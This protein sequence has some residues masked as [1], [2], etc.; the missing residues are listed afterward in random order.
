MSTKHRKTEELLGLI[1][2]VM[3]ESGLI[4][5]ADMTALGRFSRMCS[6]RLDEF[7]S[8]ASEGTEEMIP[9][10]AVQA[11]ISQALESLQA[12]HGAAG[13][14]M[15]AARQ[16]ARV[17]TVYLDSKKTSV[18][19]PAGL[20]ESVIALVGEDVATELV[21]EKAAAAQT[22]PAGQKS[23]WVAKELERF[24]LQQ[25]ALVSL[26]GQGDEEGAL[27]H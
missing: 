18:S 5:S 25:K 26:K 27:K 24:V 23:K 9:L 1:L 12:G 2:Q 4:G 8:A 6:D 20:F 17:V 13:G 10:S 21:T 3:S 22:Q 15:M 11:A 19:L 14:V 16:P 7:M